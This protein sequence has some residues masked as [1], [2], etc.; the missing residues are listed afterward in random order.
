M[1]LRAGTNGLVPNG[2]SHSSNPASINGEPSRFKTQ[3]HSRNH[4][5]DDHGQ[6]PSSA[7]GQ[8]NGLS[9]SA[10]TRDDVGRQHPQRFTKPL[11][12]RSKS[13]FARPQEQDD[14]EPGEEEIPEW[15]ARH[16]FEDHYQSE[17]IITQL[18]TNWCMYFTDKRH[19]TTGK[20][21]ALQSEL[22][23]WRQRD[24]LKTVSAALAVCLNIGVEPPDQLKTNPGAKLEAWTDPTVPPAQKALENIGKG[25]QSQYE[26]LAIRARYKQYLDPS[27][28]ET[29]KFCVSLRRNAKDERVLLHYNGHGVPKPTASGEIWV[30]NKTY[31]QYIPVSLY[32][33][34]HWLQAPTIY[35]WDCSEAGNILNNYHRFVEKHEDE[36]KETAQRDPHYEKT[37]FRPYIHLA[38]CAAKENLPTNPL[39][40]ADLFTACLTTPIEMALWFFVLQNPLPTTLT[41]ER[42]KKLP[43]RL[44]ERRTPLG[45][46]NWIFTAITDSIAWTT[47]PRDLFRKFFRQDLMVAALFRNFL[48]AQRVMMVYGCHPQ[49]Y[50]QLPDTHQHPLWETWDLAVDMALAQLPMLEKKEADG[51]EYEYQ[52]STFFTEQL[53]AFEVYLTRGDAL[54]QR[55]PDQLPVVLQVLLSQQHRVRALIL[56]GRFLDLGPWS[57]QLAL[58]IGIFP[59][60][61]KLLQS[62]ATELKPVMVFIWAR[63][64][65]V[66]ISCQQ[67]LAKDNGYAYFAQILKPTEA[68]PVVDSDEHKAMCAFILAMLCKDYQNGQMICNQTDI[69]TY[70]LTH[71]QNKDNHL[72]RQWA[73]LCISQLWQDLPEAKWRGIRENAYVTLACL[74]KDAC[75]EVRAAVIHAMTT[76]LGIPDLTEEV[77]KIEESIAW[78]ILDMGT[79]GSPM[80]RKEFLVFLSHFIVRFESKFL[81][82]AFEQLQEEK[83]YLLFPPQDD[84]HDHKMGLHYARPENRNKDGTIKPAAHGLSHN[85]VYM[86]CWKHALIL[87]VDPHPDVQRSATV[88]V[89]YMHKALINS[90][91]GEQAH[92]LM[93]DIQRRANRATFKSA[94]TAHQRRSLMSGNGAPVTAP[95]PSPGLLRRTASLLF[96]SFVGAE[97]KSRPSTPSGSVTSMAPPRSPGASLPPDQASAPPEQNDTFGAPATYNTAREP[98]SGEFEERDLTESPTLPLVSKFLDWSTEY[99]REPQMKNSE[100]DEPGSTDYNERLWRRQRNE[101]TLRETQPLKQFAGS[102]RWNNQLGIINNTVQP[103]KMTFHQYEDHLAVSDEGNTVMV[104]DWKRQGRLSKFSNGNPEGSRISDMRFINEDDQAML[105]TGSSDGVIRI[106]RNYDSDSEIELATSWRAL[107]HMVP[108]NVNSGMVFDWQQVKGRV[109]VAGDVRVIRVWYAA[110]ETCVMDIPARSGSC[111]TSLTSDQM[112]G[113]LFVAGFG[114]GAVRV[115]D[116]RLK[117]QESMV[118]K[119]KDE[120]DRQW[121]KAVHMQRGGQRE[122]MSA[123][124]NGKVKIWDIRMDKALRSFQTTRDTLRTAST[125][126]HLPVFAVGTSTHSVKIFNLEGAELSRLEP[127]SSFLQQNRGAPISATAFH[128]HRPILGCAARGDH[129]INLFTCEKG[130][131]LNLS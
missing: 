110:S 16:G 36:E 121:I 9:S 127:Y 70:C 24:R 3:D 57:V 5:P 66:D 55:P 1:T 129:H 87:S 64:I 12:V 40:P 67:D 116:T 30:F 19:E 62:A 75:C 78:T 6:R 41:P 115:F 117:P 122:L 93:R 18:A 88:I 17:H 37:A 80:V 45:E 68:L 79:D 97:D 95:L 63:L 23:D 7:P 96:Q 29:K 22:H 126:E 98:I 8:K 113:D 59:Y 125:H 25:L 34:Q 51:T 15:G 61:L 49:S 130:E 102:H 82:T 103:A 14:S 106:Y 20:P 81:V 76:F 32:D 120:S 2:H 4:S 83:D 26:T 33:L 28:E 91:V 44:Q 21:K 94:A 111:V 53:T 65:A 89:D 104:W 58:S 86:A 100:A 56:L 131:P 108:S 92:A 90:P 85:S 118:R 114:D 73:C 27:V 50:P 10:E 43:G 99:F 124:R 128:P 35:V 69:M 42:A 13:D 109:L 39:L 38:A 48:L 47:L 52:N 77:A 71:I 107:T 74:T 72:L 54:A 31:T 60:V 105:L 11:L 119:W 112:T 84:G 46:L 123:S 101:T